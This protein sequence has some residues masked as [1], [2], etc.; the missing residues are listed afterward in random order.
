MKT[1][2]PLRKIGPRIF[3]SYSFSDRVLA[4]TLSNHLAQLGFQV[5]Q[6]DETSL[7]GQNLRVV[8]PQR[9]ADSEVV[10]PLLTTTSNKSDWVRQEIDWALEQKKKRSNLLILPVVF[11]NTELYAPIRDW[12]YINAIS[13]G[14]TDALLELISR[15][16]LR[17]VQCLPLRDDEI[18]TFEPTCV[19]EILVSDDPY[20]KRVIV[21]SDGTILS[22]VDEIIEAA[23][24]SKSNLSAAFMDQAKQRRERIIQ[25][26]S[27]ADVIFPKMVEELKVCFSEYGTLYP[28]CAVDAVDRFSRQALGL[29][30]LKLRQLVLPR[31]S[32]ILAFLQPQLDGAASFIEREQQKVPNHSV[33][34]EMAWVLGRRSL[35]NSHDWIGIG[36][37]P[38]ENKQGVTLYFPKTGI[39]SDWNFILKLG[40]QPNASINLYDWA[41]FCIP[42]LA[43]RGL[44]L[45]YAHSLT[46]DEVDT[47]IAWGRAEYSRM[48][49]P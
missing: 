15:T 13:S 33:P 41:D 11:D 40:D 5:R 18:F 46:L 31:D 8:L 45:M 4:D 2:N 24:P 14:L 49:L 6:E 10:I 28:E 38:K 27:C 30:L 35:D 26:L 21:D 3:I 43:V 37:A 23:R 47:T 36:F 19:R 29:E 25:L 20:G 42:Q 34:A 12:V 9:I 16:C 48:G 22:L 32:P 44:G 39:G 17:T 7:L 1:A